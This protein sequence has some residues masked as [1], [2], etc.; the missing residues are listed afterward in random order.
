M[1]LFDFLKSSRPEPD[2]SRSR[3]ARP[4]HRLGATP[5][6]RQRRD[7]LREAATTRPG[8]HPHC[9]DFGEQDDLPPSG[10]TERRATSFDRNDRE[11]EDREVTERNDNR[12]SESRPQ[13]QRKPRIPASRALQ[14]ARQHL[15]GL[16]GLE[17]ESVSGVT[18]DDGRWKVRFEVVELQRVPSTTD[19]IASYEV[20]LDENGDLAGCHRVERYYR[21]Q[22]GQG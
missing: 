8:S 11:E 12:E 21:N 14:Q 16:T 7:R 19:V 3:S 5:A 10:N 17:P 22:A 20:E 1:A 13:R 2:S 6:D 15:R 18:S 4:S 9:R